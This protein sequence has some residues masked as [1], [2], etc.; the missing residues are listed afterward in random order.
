[1]KE[2]YLEKV[3]DFNY[4]EFIK[5]S[6]LEKDGTIVINEDA[7][8]IDK[9]TKK[10]LVIYKLLPDEAMHNRVFDTLR[11]IKYD[12]NQ[13]AS[14]LV[15]RSKIFGFVP[16]NRI[17]TS[18]QYCR[19]ANLKETDPDKHQLITDYAR[20]IN[21]I[22]EDGNKDAYEAHREMTAKVLDDYVIPGTLFT[23]GIIN[24]NNPLKYHFDAGNFVNVNSAMIAFKKN[25][26][27]GRLVL[28]EYNAKLEIANRTITLFD[29]QEILHG[30]TPI[31]EL[32]PNDSYRFTM[33]FYSLAGMWS[34][35]PL[36]EEIANAR[37]S[38]FDSEMAKY[39]RKFD[40]GELEKV[41]DHHE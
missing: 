15:S 33:V 23:S 37:Q 5:R 3:K 34:C 1:M 11:R 41:E 38:R 7:V 9:D 17:K 8:L 25:V 26:G 14:G 40:K 2:I 10:V 4:K 35:L 36:S 18:D 13:R 16:R 31:D 30:V 27:G 24:Y 20:Y 21:D 12:T 6:A 29:G 28:P 32:V 22:Y 19:V 39:K